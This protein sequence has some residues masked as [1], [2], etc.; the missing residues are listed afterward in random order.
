MQKTETEQ[1]QAIEA[2]VAE[3]KGLV[4]VIIAGAIVFLA[5]T[6]LLHQ[7]RKLAMLRANLLEKSLKEKQQL[8]ADVSHK[9]RTPLTTLKLHIQALQHDIVSNVEDSYDKLDRKVNEIN[10]LISD[11]YYLAQADTNSLELNLIEVDVGELFDEWQEDWQSLIEGSGFSWQYTASLAEATKII[12]ADRIKQVIDNLLTNAIKYT[13]K[14]GTILL[15]AQASDEQLIVSVEDTAPTVSE[16]KLSKIFSR[17]C[18]VESSRN[19]QTGGS[20]LGLA[21]C[22]SLIKAHHGTIAAEQSELG[23]L[24]ITF[25]I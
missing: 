11:I 23:G 22:E 16:D 17:L 5:L 7:R 19:R 15:T 9:L 20:G 2:Q 4:T 1:A 6:F 3:K 25:R 13:D 12:D 24:R 10:N 14:P 21:I 8:F 18:R